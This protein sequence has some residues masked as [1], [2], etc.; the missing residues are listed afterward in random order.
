MI[1]SRLLFQGYGVSLKM[2]PYQAGLLGVDTLVVLDEAHLV[3]P[4]THLLRAIEQV[5]SLWPHDAADRARLARFAVLPLSATQRET[6]KDLDGRP[7]FRLSDGDA[8][9]KIVERRLKARKRLRLAELAE[10]E[11]DKQVAEAAWE[12]AT[13][14]GKPARVVVFCVDDLAQGAHR[15]PRGGA[16]AARLGRGRGA[17]DDG[18]LAQAPPGANCR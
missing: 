13:R 6:G 8:H 9:D 5:T 10:K 1:G 7:P 16:L 17:A 3:P 18:G 15:P 14:P 2:R 4:F 12:L 11:Q